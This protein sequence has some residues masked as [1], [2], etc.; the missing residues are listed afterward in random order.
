VAVNT[1][2]HTSTQPATTEHPPYLYIRE[3]ELLTDL[4]A[5]VPHGQKHDPREL[6]ALASPAQDHDQLGPHHAVTDTAVDPK[7]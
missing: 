4:H 1:A 2:A 3:D 5:C 6:A 7:N